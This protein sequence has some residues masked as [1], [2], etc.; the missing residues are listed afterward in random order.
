[1]TAMQAVTEAATIAKRSRTHARIEDLSWLLS[2]GEWPPRAVERVGWTMQAAEIACRRHGRED[3]A[4]ILHR[5][6][7]LA[8]PRVAA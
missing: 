8:R 6:V 5:E 1:M 4:T 7:S 3:I 2:F